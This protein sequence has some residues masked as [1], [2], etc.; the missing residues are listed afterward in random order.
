MAALDPDLIAQIDSRILNIETTV[1]QRFVTNE[2]TINEFVEQLKGMMKNVEDNDKAVKAE[3]RDKFD[4]LAQTTNKTTAEIQAAMIV[5]QASYNAMAKSTEDKVAN[6]ID[7]LKNAINVQNNRVAK[8]ESDGP[9]VTNR[10]AQAEGVVQELKVS[11]INVITGIK[12][13]IGGSSTVTT[14]GQKEDKL[15]PIT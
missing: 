9:I 1:E 14:L 6:E 2:K 13:Q 10:L 15:K 11:T 3:L 5:A 8:I 12:I 4:V 7:S